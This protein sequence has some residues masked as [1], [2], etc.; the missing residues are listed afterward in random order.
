MTNGSANAAYT[1][2]AAISTPTL[3]TRAAHA[4]IARGRGAGAG[5]AAPP[6]VR[7]VI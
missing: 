2:S 6:A 7:G 3:S 4:G 1:T 5:A